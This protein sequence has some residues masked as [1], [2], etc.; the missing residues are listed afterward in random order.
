MPLPQSAML[1][2]EIV[3]RI[4]SSEWTAFEVLNAY[5]AQA[6][7]AHAAATIRLTEVLFD[8]AREEARKLDQHF[9][10]TGTVKGP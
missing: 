5:I 6:A 8:E 1:A 4:A 9:L 3:Q 10:T 7:K 2:S